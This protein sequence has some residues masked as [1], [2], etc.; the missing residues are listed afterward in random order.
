M[1]NLFEVQVFFTDL[2]FEIFQFTNKNKRGSMSFTIT[3]NGKMQK[4][5]KKQ[6]Y[7]SKCFFNIGRKLMYWLK[8]FSDKQFVL[9]EIINQPPLGTNKL[10]AEPFG[11]FGIQRA[12]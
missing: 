3:P 6:L 9:Q 5:N 7:G 12:E 8:N 1:E 10:L 2:E 11:Y 4:C